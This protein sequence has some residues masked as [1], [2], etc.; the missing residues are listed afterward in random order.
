[1]K[2]LAGYDPDTKPNYKKQVDD[3][4][5]KIEQSCQELLDLVRA[6]SPDEAQSSSKLLDVSCA[7]LFFWHSCES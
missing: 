1:M 7:V 3:Q 6:I 4:L 2:V 5:K